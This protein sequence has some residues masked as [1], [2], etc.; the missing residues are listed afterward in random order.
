MG[1][2]VACIKNAYVRQARSVALSSL[3]R[4]S[5]FKLSSSE[6]LV[7]F[8]PPTPPHGDKPNY[9][10]DC[11]TTYLPVFVFSNE[12]RFLWYPV[13][14]VPHFFLGSKTHTR[15]LLLCNFIT[16]MSLM[17]NTRLHRIDE[18]LCNNRLITHPCLN[19]DCYC[20]NMAKTDDEIKK[21]NFACV[22][23]TMTD[24]MAG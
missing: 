11:L 17:W 14:E 19:V 4:F 10:F 9:L 12:W 8:N 20:W 18:I 2:P 5:L 6:L 15:N 24:Q 16:W 7:T 23:L 21:Y 13:W 1:S 3:N 22:N